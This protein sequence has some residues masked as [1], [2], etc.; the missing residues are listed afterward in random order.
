MQGLN[1]IDAI[2]QVL[3]A[4]GV[5]YEIKSLAATPSDSQERRAANSLLPGYASR[6]RKVGGDWVGAGW[7]ELRPVPWPWEGGSPCQYRPIGAM[8]LLPV[9]SPASRREQQR[10]GLQKCATRPSC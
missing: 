8:P 7:I 10:G 4:R 2:I 1:E 3:D 9:L 6:L 5:L